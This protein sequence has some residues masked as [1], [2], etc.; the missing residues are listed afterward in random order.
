MF[1]YCYYN[2]EYIIF[3]LL[4]FFTSKKKKKRVEYMV[5]YTN[6]ILINAQC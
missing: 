2:L 6:T 1:S 4:I 5:Q 3:D